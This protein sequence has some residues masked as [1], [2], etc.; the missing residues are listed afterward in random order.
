[1]NI[2]DVLCSFAI[3]DK[4]YSWEANK[5]GLINKSYVISDLPGEKKYFLQQID[6][7]IFKD[8][9]GLM[10]NIDVVG[11][12]F[13]RLANP[14]PLIKLVPTKKGNTYLKATGPTYWRLYE[15]VDGQTFFRASD[16]SMAA[17]AGRAFGEFLAALSNIDVNQVAVT[18][19]GFHSMELRYRQFQE[20]KTRAKPERLAIAQELIQV[21]SENIEAMLAYQEELEHTARLVVTH[22]DTKLS[23][24][25]FDN[26]LKAK[27]VI[28][29]DTLMPGYLPFDYGDSVR[30]ICSRTEEDSRDLDN[31]KYDIELLQSFTHAFLAALS[32]QISSNEVALLPRAICF[33]PFIMGLRMLTDYLNND[34]YYS[35]EYLEHNLHRAENQFTLYLNGLALQDEIIKIVNQKKPKA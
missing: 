10:H 27:V 33:M 3:A 14:P 28:D 23:N 29:Y 32:D 20:A 22:N 30:T 15:Y 16:T 35:T 9:A 19:A 24:L 1:M 17:E 2:E 25:L 34:I 11:D 5:Q 7:V 26:H 4:E 8:I 13:K 21:V 31:T 18:L 12:H 6:H